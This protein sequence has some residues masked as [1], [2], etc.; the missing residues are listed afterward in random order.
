MPFGS[1]GFLQYPTN[2][3]AKS[4]VLGTCGTPSTPICITNTLKY[5]YSYS[6]PTCGSNVLTSVRLE[7]NNGGYNYPGNTPFIYICDSNI[8]DP[9]NYVYGAI[10]ILTDTSNN[11]PHKFPCNIYPS[12]LSGSGLYFGYPILKASPITRSYTYNDIEYFTINK[13]TYSA[14]IQNQTTYATCPAS[15]YL[16]FSDVTFSNSVPSQTITI[17]PI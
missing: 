12:S 17:T 1:R 7:S 3:T 4:G 10:I 16:S 8:A 9:N 14:I 13:G 11:T 6:A 5:G 15:N 2:Y